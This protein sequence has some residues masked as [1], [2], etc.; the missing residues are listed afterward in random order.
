MVGR[1]ESAS[2]FR[3]MNAHTVIQV[4]VCALVCVCVC[5]CFGCVLVRVWECLHVEHEHELTMMCGVL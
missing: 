2:V 3:T 1:G 4:M 5:V